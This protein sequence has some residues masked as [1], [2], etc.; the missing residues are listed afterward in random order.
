MARSRAVDARE[1]G[2]IREEAALS[3]TAHAPWGSL[4]GVSDRKVRSGTSFDGG[5]TVHYLRVSRAPL[6]SDRMAALITF[7]REFSKRKWY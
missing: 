1:P 7:V 6:A 4:A 5:C 3:D 2:Q